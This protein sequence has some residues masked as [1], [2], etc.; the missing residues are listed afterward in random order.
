MAPVDPGTSTVY[1]P[2]PTTQ[3]RKEVLLWTRTRSDPTVGEDEKG[4]DWGPRVDVLPLV[5]D[6]NG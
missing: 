3:I 6:S 1:N 4:S 2:S 5:F